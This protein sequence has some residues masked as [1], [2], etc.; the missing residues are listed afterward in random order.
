MDQ[1]ILP[2]Q[3]RRGRPSQPSSNEHEASKAFVPLTR[4]HEPDPILGK[5]P[6]YVKTAS[7]VMQHQSDIM[8]SNSFPSL[9]MNDEQK[10]KMFTLKGR[11][12]AEYI[13]QLREEMRKNLRP[14][15]TPEP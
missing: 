11:E 6:M 2:V 1:F 10:Q 5:E 14:P 12:R 9:H 13:K 15:S 8:R 3:A 7:P 4:S